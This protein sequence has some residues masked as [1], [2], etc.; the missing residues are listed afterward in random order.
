MV[1]PK[2]IKTNHYDVLINAI[3]IYTEYRLE[4]RCEYDLF[5]KNDIHSSNRL[6]FIQDLKTEEARVLEY[7]DEQ[8]DVFG[9]C[10]TTEAVKAVAFATSHFMIANRYRQ[11]GL[12]FNNK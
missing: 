3:D 8:R 7:Y 10:S 11:L 5:D 6:K 12:V 9:A 1:H 2:T 4:D